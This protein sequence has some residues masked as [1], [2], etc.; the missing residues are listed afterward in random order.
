M[1]DAGYINR[2]TG[3]RWVRTSG[4]LKGVPFGSSF[5]TEAALS[6]DQ[7]RRAD[8]IAEV[9]KNIKLIEK[10]ESK[11]QTQVDDGKKPSETKQ[12]PPLAETSTS[13]KTE[14]TRAEIKIPHAELKAGNNIRLS[15]ALV[16]KMKNIAAEYNQATGKNLTITDGNRSSLE[17]SYMMIKQIRKGK[18]GIYGEKEAAR[19]I[20]RAYDAAKAQGKSDREI[21]EDINQVIKSQIK[22]GTFI[23]PHL[24][25]KGTDVRFWDM[26]ASDKAKF[27]QIVN[28]YGGEVVKENDH[29]HL[30]FK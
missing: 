12:T 9:L 30:Q 1:A 22:K 2:E 18:L 7:Q 28:K 17:Q 23:S 4:R 11:T 13:D 20:G 29:F 19:E 25:N 24:T 6:R 16:G 26:S 21:A 5:K 15:P 10:S 27:I 14:L 3:Q 8:A